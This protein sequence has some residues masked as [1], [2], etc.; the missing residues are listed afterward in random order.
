MF[1]TR[2]PEQYEETLIS[3][4]GAGSLRA[5]TTSGLPKNDPNAEGRIITEKIEEQYED[6]DYFV[7]VPAY[8]AASR[9]KERARG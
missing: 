4:T 5:S 2:S 1:R 9:G 8:R 7:T 6:P 3:K